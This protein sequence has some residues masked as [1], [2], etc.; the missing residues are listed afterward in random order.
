VTTAISL[1][2]LIP[3]DL[4]LGFVL[5]HPLKSPRASSRHRMAPGIEFCNQAVSHRRDNGT[6]MIRLALEKD[7]GSPIP[8][9]THDVR[10]RAPRRVIHPRTA[11]NAQ[12]QLRRC[13]DL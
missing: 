6:R 11:T 1:F 3:A 7:E 2:V 13:T 5:L 4:E 10:Q 9:S 12:Q 8:A